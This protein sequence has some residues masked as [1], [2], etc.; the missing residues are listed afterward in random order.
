MPK[1]TLSPLASSAIEGASFFA[2]SAKPYSSVCTSVMGLSASMIGI[3]EPCLHLSNPQ[4]RC[5]A[6]DVDADSGRLQTTS[7]LAHLWV[8]PDRLCLTKALLT[9]DCFRGSELIVRN[10]GAV[11]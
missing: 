9:D 8:R 4:N 5:R 11:N 1:T 2:I 10:G 6:A 3:K 7:L